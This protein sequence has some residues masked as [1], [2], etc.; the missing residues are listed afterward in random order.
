M[1]AAEFD[2]HRPDTLDDALALLADGEA[3]PLA[4]GQ[5]LMPMMNFR[6]ARP[7][8][9][10][11]LN[12][13]PGLAEV[14]VSGN[15]VQIGAMTRYADLESNSD[16]QGLLPLITRALPHIAHS[17]IRNR[18][19]IGGSCALADPAA[20]MP[21]VLLALDAEIQTLS[22]LGMRRIPADEFFL[23]LYETALTEGEIVHWILFPVRGR[24][25]TGFHEITRRHGD[26]ATAGCAIAAD[27]DLS[28]V[29]VAV[30]G[31]SDRALRATGAEAALEGSDGGEAAVNAAVAALKDI[32]FAGD[33]HAGVETK[34]HLAGVAL[35]RAWA[36]VM[37]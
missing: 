24:Q 20:E 28:R 23:G 10:V 37:A 35:R 1:K 2:Y 19:T 6:L 8:A 18:A 31:V 25:R 16:V 15:S 9:L 21:A 11:D 29:R 5:S 12:R 14:T 7:E 34:R 33:L 30:F 27:Q 36:E 22:H 13:I 17:A 3:M 4:G 32:D 26:Y